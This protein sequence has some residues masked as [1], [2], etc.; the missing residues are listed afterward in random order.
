[1]DSNATTPAGQKREGVTPVPVVITG[2]GV[3]CPI[4]RTPKELLDNIRECRGGIGEIIA[5]DTSGLKTKHAAEIRDYDALQYFSPHEVEVLDKTAQFAI[6]AA[7]SALEASG[8]DLDVLG[9]DRI[10]IVMG[11]CAGGQGDSNQR[12]PVDA[13]WATDRKARTMLSTAHYV[14][15]DAVVWK[16]GLEGPEATIS[17]ACASSATAMSYA[18]ELIQAGKA[19]V[20]LAGGAD[21]FSL[22]TYAGFYALGAMPVGPCS[23]FSE[24]IGVTFGEGAG[25]VVLESLDRALARSARIHGEL[26]AYGATGDA[27]H[28]TSPHPSGE[29]LKRALEMAMARSGLSIDAIDYVNAHGTGTRDNDTS[30]TMAI[31]ELFKGR[32]IC[33][34]VSSTKSYF[35]HTLGAAGILEFIV[36]LLCQEAGLIPPTLNFTTPRPGCDLDYVPNTPREVPIRYFLSTS[37]A[38]GGVNAALVG[39]A[40][41]P[42][43]HRPA[44]HT[45][46][47]VITGVGVV[48]SIGSGSAEFVE[49]LR[50]GRCGIGP[51]D[52]FD[53]SDCRSRRAGLIRDFKPRRLVPTLDLRRLDLLNQY[54]A[55]AAGLALKEA[56]LDRAPLPPERV[57]M[58]MGLTRGPVGAQERF[59]ESLKNDGIEGL[60][61]KHFPSMVI[62]T[63]GGQVS[64]AFGCM[65][66]NST[67]VDGVTAGLHALIHA[68]ELLRQNDGQDAV[69]VVAAD[70]IAALLFRVLDRLGVLAPTGEN[71]EALRPYD[72]GAIGMIMGEGAA[73]LVLERA[74]S[75]AGRGATV[76]A[77]VAGYGLAG[78]GGSPSYLQPEPSGRQLERAI[79][80]ALEEA[81][82]GPEVLDVVYGHGRGIPAQDQREVQAVGRVLAGRPVP[83]GCVLGHIGVAEA[84]SGLF[85]V[86][87]AVLGMARSEAYPVAGGD[88]SL[89]GGLA[90]VRGGPL[91]GSYRRALVAGSTETGNN[92]AVV[93]TTVAAGA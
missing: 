84:A 47:V 3:F 55:V 16:L 86:A 58:V 29:G 12:F 31:R 88:N 87:A 72:P 49:A 41:E 60:S 20:I 69:V 46:R 71:A 17:T 42:K 62:S 6:L 78:D 52:R 35:G 5:F 27:H 44:P 36:S 73:A 65:G 18:Y 56:G 76:L 83:V 57:G 85:S 54:A 40:V 22:N 7:R 89:A 91:A 63:A 68:F 79:R 19:D 70:E 59:L 34:P 80:L 53:V 4:G 13:P 11:V 32:P 8:L 2:I 28:I 1:M 30:E 21:A 82:I 38:F 23:P 43:R 24:G 25:F 26:L 33:P 81:R 45:D 92:A 10:G 15:T 77:E 39:G 37:A 64:Q 61:A 74:S 66:I 75:A 14:Q 50:Q 9:R 48:S 67:L 93:L 51:I 90:Y